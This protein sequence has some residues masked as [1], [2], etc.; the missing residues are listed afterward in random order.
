MQQNNLNILLGW[1]AFWSV[2]RFYGKNVVEFHL[3][4]CILFFWTLL[5]FTC[6][7][8]TEHTFLP[9]YYIKILYVLGLLH[10]C[11]NDLYILIYYLLSYIITEY[12]YVGIRETIS[13][14][15]IEYWRHLEKYVVNLLILIYVCKE[16]YKMV[17]P[18]DK[19]HYIRHTQSIPFPSFFLLEHDAGTLKF[20]RLNKSTKKWVKNIY[21]KFVRTNITNIPFSWTWKIFI[22]LKF[23]FHI[24]FLLY[25]KP[26]LRKK[27]YTQ[28]STFY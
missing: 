12:F 2:F 11:F 14:C 16:I 25:I 3:S 20:M 15:C 8:T 24:E 5:I 17:Q 26:H 10:N 18:N 19:C 21:E 1:Y 22:I 28:N 4:W 27:K 7:V 13:L 9:K 6:F 23:L